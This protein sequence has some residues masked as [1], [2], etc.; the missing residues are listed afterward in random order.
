MRHG[1]PAIGLFRRTSRDVV[2]GDVAIP[3]DSTVWIAYLAGNHDVTQFP[4]P[5]RLDLERQNA[6]GH[7]SFGHGIHYCIGASLAKAELRLVIEELTQHYPSLRL[8]VGQNL[9]PVQNF[10]LRAYQEM[11]LEID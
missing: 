7:L 3:K 2:L 1:G 6:S 4:N 9:M 5:D 11:V 8:A 10:M